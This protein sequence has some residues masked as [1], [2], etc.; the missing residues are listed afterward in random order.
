M[1]RTDDAAGDSPAP[2]SHLGP[3]VRKDAQEPG[4]G[5]NEE[6]NEENGHEEIIPG[7]P[8]LRCLWMVE[9]GGVEPG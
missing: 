7:L 1:S 5:S 3:P 4:A 9:V 8:K 6:I 2:L